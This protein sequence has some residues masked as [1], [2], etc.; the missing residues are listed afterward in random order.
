MEGW[1]KIMIKI[2]LIGESPN[3]TES[4]KNILS[5]CYKD[6][7]KFKILLNNITGYYLDSA[8]T[9]KMLN[10]E[11]YE[12][13]CLIIVIRDLDD[14]NYI[15]DRNDWFCKL[16][17]IMK[18]KGIFLLNIYELEAIFLSDISSFNKFFK[19]TIKYNKNPENEYDPKEYLKLKTRQEKKD[20]K[21]QCKK[22]Y[23]ENDSPD[24][25]KIVD[26]TVLKN[27][28]NYFSKFIS[29]FEK[30]FKKCESIQ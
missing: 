15:K 12:D 28:L 5:R 9:F 30:K 19:T 18:G 16:N 21:S 20:R 3:D 10:F 2:G 29:D 24:L 6:Q 17:I 4:I 13:Y 22:I 14:D 8:K 26:V 23:S 11:N 1:K 25:C 27:K 7:V